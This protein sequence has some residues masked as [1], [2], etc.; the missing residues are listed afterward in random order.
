MQAIATADEIESSFNITK[1]TKE[2]RA[3]SEA[4]IKTGETWCTMG[5]CYAAFRQSKTKAD[6]QLAVE[7]AMVAW[8][9]NA[10]GKWSSLD[11]LPKFLATMVT[12]SQKFEAPLG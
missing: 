6:L 5:L 4:A 3:S 1:M 11:R 10:E 9:K 7:G 12:K 8:P 2:L